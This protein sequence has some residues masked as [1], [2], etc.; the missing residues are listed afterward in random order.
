MLIEELSRYKQW[1]IHRA[2]KTPLRLADGR[3]ASPVDPN[4]WT[5]YEEASNFVAVHSDFGLGFVLTDSD[6]YSV[7]DLD[8]HKID[9]DE[10]LSIEQKAACKANH[11]EIFKSFDTYTELSP[12]KGGAH[13]WCYGS[14]PSRKFTKQHLEV[15]SSNRYITVT[16]NVIK[17]GGIKHRQELLNELVAAIDIATNRKAESDTP[18]INLAEVYTDDEICKRAASASN[19]ELF[20]QL[21]FG[22]WQGKYPSQ[23]EADIA[24]CNIVAFYTDNQ[25]Q[26]GRIYYNS[27]L[28]LESPK[29]KRKQRPDYLFHKQW[30]IVTKAFDQ[31]IPPVDLSKVAIS[32]AERMKEIQIL[33]KEEK[34]EE[35]ISDEDNPV[36]VNWHRPSGLLGD[37]A[38]YIW[39]QSIRPNIEIS[40]AGAITFMAG[41]AGRSFNT[42]TG[43]GLNQYI[44]LLAGTG[45]GK[46]AA[47]RGI[48][49]LYS[50]VLKQ[51]PDVIR[52][53][54]PSEIA[55]SQALLK[56][57]AD[58]NCFWSHKDEFGL[59]L[60]KLNHKHASPYDRQLKSLLLALYNKSGHGEML[61]GSIYSD[62]KNNAPMV[63]APS[64]TLYGEST[65][66]EFYKA[67]DETTI[68]DGFIP[69]LTVIPVPR[70]RPQFNPEGGKYLPPEGLIWRISGLL[71]RVLEIEQTQSVFIVPETPEAKEYQLAYQK[72]CDDAVWKDNLGTISELW[73]RAHVKLLKLGAL[74][75][76]GNNSDNPEIHL[77]DYQWAEQLIECGT[78]SITNRFITGEI[79]EENFPL[80]QRKAIQ[81][82]LKKYFNSEWK[83]SFAKSYNINF[84]MWKVRAIGYSYIQRKT[85]G[86][87]CFRK[88]PNPS[89]ALKQIIQEC[90]DIGMLERS[91]ETFGKGGLI[92]RVKI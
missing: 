4:D 28:F 23:S 86:L 25:Q 44:V 17:N 10:A 1:V 85:V 87:A 88:V 22:Q 19:G 32:V 5:S 6:P 61:A 75:A 59:W 58:S 73:N 20:K 69:R 36:A 48:S 79:G 62:K 71:K 83:D 3:P 60:Q 67:V 18:T 14:A 63:K 35:F 92:Y 82:L 39:A 16:N 66:Q 37:I 8:T 45:Q 50:A 21:W 34:D 72:K 40:V 15:Y 2:D 70:I 51:V 13:I 46:E 38:E 49:R 27:P 78:K 84:D 33:D 56:Y 55:S 7:I 57:F 30:G 53:M 91:A 89:F 52:F 68:N 12:S 24:F 65:P 90:I 43:T 31:K 42:I 26:V 76:V 81:D 64:L 54:G 29:R 9:N 11:S 80:A 74:L 41:L 77:S 47:A